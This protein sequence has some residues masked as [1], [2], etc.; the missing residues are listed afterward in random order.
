MSFTLKRALSCGLF[1]ATMVALASCYEEL[2]PQPPAAQQSP[3]TGQPGP[4]NQHISQGGGSAL[5]AAKRSATN[6]VQKAQEAQKKAIREVDPS[7][8][9]DEP[10][11]N[12]DDE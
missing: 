9:D 5:G 1:C 2:E 6:T 10:P 11:P 12:P 7:I 4:L 3:T 8:V